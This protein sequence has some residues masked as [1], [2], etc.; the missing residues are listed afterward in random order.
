MKKRILKYTLSDKNYVPGANVHAIDMPEGAQVLTARWQQSE[1]GKGFAIWCLVDESQPKQAREFVVL[2]TG[3]D[4]WNPR[5]I[6][7]ATC[8]KPSG[9]IWHVFETP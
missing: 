3:D 1:Y 8:E 6:Y 2:A 7:I 4:M 9:T 5:A